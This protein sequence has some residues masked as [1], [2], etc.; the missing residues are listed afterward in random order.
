M[1]VK[2]LASKRPVESTSKAMKD[3]NHPNSPAPTT[4]RDFL[5]KTSTAVAGGTL[6]GG[7]SLE[8]SAFAAG[9]DTL[10]IALIGCGGRGS[11]AADQALSTSGG[12]KLV[13]MADV[14]KDQLEGS[15]NN[16]KKEHKETVEVNEDT[17][18]IGFDAYKHAIASADVVV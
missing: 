7:L 8:R 13:A 1:S 12:V 10:R 6:L 4:R 9:S 18:F 3:L 17:M 14:F 5:K 11:G 16:L 15:L 2:I